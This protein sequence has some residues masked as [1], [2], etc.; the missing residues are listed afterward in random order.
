MALHPA[1]SI[2]A[3]GL[4]GDLGGITYVQRGGNR[5]TSYA[6]TYPKRTPSGAQIIFRGRFRE[7]VSAW[8]ALDDEHKHTLDLIAEHFGMVMSGYNVFISTWLSRNPQWIPDWA[9]QINRTW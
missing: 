8:H 4:T 7:A 3:M 5:R 1:S 6:K 2:I 9:Q